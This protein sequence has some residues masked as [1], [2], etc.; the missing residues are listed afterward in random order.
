VPAI[1]FYAV[2]RNRVSTISVDTQLQA[3]EFL[4]HFA[5]AARGKNPPPAA[6][7]AVAQ[8]APAAPAAIKPARPAQP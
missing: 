6:P 4:R 8:A 5:H 3:D 1:Y 7:V 2:F